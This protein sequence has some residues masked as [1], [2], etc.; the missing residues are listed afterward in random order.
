MK[1]VGV[2]GTGTMGCGI[3]QVAAQT[4][5]EVIFQ[6]RKEDSVA[7]GLDQVVPL[8]RRDPAELGCDVTGLV[9]GHYRGAGHEIGA[10]LPR[11]VE[12]LIVPVEKVPFVGMG[13]PF[14]LV[15]S[16]PNIEKAAALAAAASPA[17]PAPTTRT[18]Q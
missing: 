8:H 4:R 15:G 10:V 2:I 11:E 17:G 13:S 14:Q 12:R 3:A 18:S 5:C 16:L 7:K 9:S 6:N 1:I